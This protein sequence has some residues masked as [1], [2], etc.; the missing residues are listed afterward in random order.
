MLAGV[1]LAS[2]SSRDKSTRSEAVCALNAYNQLCKHFVILSGRY[3]G[4]QLE[5]KFKKT[6]QSLLRNFEKI[7]RFLQMLTAKYIL[8]ILS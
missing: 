1:E 7:L 6:I 4:V 3:S 2:V 8:I 5:Q